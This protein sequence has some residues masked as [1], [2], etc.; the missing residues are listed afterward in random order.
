M[1]N[2]FEAAALAEAS[3]NCAL[4]TPTTYKKI[5]WPPKEIYKQH[6]HTRVLVVLQTL[7][8]IPSPQIHRKT[9]IEKERKFYKNDIKLISDT[10]NPHHVLFRNNVNRLI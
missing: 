10:I 2:I 3:M 7:D 4:F 1:R 6:I 9:E 5:V 8:C